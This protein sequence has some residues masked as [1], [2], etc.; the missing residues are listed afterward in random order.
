MNQ[1]LAPLL[2]VFDQLKDHSDEVQTGSSGEVPIEQSLA[3]VLAQGPP[4]TWEE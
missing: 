2:M 1:P 4:D 3:G